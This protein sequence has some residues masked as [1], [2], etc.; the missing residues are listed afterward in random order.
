MVIYEYI[1]TVTKTGYDMETNR[2]KMKD[3]IKKTLY[4]L[5]FF[6]TDSLSSSLRSSEAIQR[7][8]FEF[9]VC[10]LRAI[11]IAF[12]FKLG[13]HFPSFASRVSLREHGVLFATLCFAQED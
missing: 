8:V 13:F 9:E 5:N 12:V 3:Q 4:R 11:S 2:S 10:S 1:C 7:V 6:L